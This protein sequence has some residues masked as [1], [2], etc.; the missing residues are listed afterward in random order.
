MRLAPTTR[1]QLTDEKAKFLEQ[2]LEDQSVME[3]ELY[4]KR[5]RNGA[6]PLS[7][8][9]TWPLSDLKDDDVILVGKSII[10]FNMY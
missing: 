6:K 2:V 10:Y 9:K 7:S 4:V 5:L 1:V 3:S 8:A